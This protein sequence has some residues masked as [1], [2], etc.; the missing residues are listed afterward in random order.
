M[1][2]LDRADV[3]GG[4]ATLLSTLRILG[5]TEG[6]DSYSYSSSSLLS[7]ARDAGSHIASAALDR[8]E[9]EKEWHKV[10][11]WIRTC[12]TLL[13]STSSGKE[14]ANEI[15][16]L[17]SVGVSLLEVITVMRRG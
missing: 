8:T 1:A 6:D 2:F 14:D 3:A 16:E 4:E 10:R 7:K 15:V 17:V 13:E 5:I 12:R 9:D 11:L